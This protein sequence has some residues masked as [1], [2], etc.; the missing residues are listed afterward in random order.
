[1][2]AMMMVPTLLGGIS[3]IVATLVVSSGVNM[4][5]SYT[6]SSSFSPPSSTQTLN[7][8]V[9]SDGQVIVPSKIVDEIVDDIKQMSRRDLLQL[10]L[11][12]DVPSSLPSI[13]GDWNGVLLDNNGPVMSTVSTI[14]TDG[15]FG[16]GRKW[17]G[18]AFHSLARKGINRFSPRRVGEDVSAQSDT[19]FEHQFDLSFENSRLDPK[20]ESLT[21]RYSNYQS[22]LS[23]W[24]SMRDEVRVLCLDE[25]GRGILL[26]LGC[27]KWSGALWRDGMMNSSPF[28][29]FR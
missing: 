24:H 2:V 20:S 3:T 26:G 4:F 22:R 1:M 23:L 5:Q 25:E 15:L 14:L 8:Y 29:L 7:K 16:R 13:D 11:R 6:L 10:W 9:K 18:K 21:L 27:M 17:K 19:H 12:C 28:C